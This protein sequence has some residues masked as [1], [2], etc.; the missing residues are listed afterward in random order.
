MSQAT[1]MDVTLGARHRGSLCSSAGDTPMSDRDNKL[2]MNL[3]VQTAVLNP[4]SYSVNWVTQSLTLQD[5]G[6]VAAV[7][8]LK[9]MRSF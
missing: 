4:V 5:T 6:F 9:S 1:M 8:T 3:R 7:C 2:H